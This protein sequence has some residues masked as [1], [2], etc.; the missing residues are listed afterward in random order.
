VKNYISCLPC[1]Q[2]GI[3]CVDKKQNADFE[4][5][6]YGNLIVDNNKGITEIIYNH[7]N[8][9]KKI[10]VGTNRTIEYLYACPPKCNE[11]GMQT[12]QSSKRR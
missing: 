1:R 11:G 3:R 10:T 7:L 6:D 5:D 2:A 8:L 4:Y 12:V 9:P